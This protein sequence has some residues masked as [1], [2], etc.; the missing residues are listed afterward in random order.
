MVAAQDVAQEK[1][2]APQI[3]TVNLTLRE[4]EI[5]TH[6]SLLSRMDCSYS[7]PCAWESM[8]SL[9]WG[10]CRACRVMP[11]PPGQFQH[12]QIHDW[13]GTL[14]GGLVVREDGRFHAYGLGDGL[15][16]A[17]EGQSGAR[18]VKT[19][20]TCARQDMPD[21]RTKHSD[22]VGGGGT[23]LSARLRPGAVPAR[24]GRRLSGGRARHAVRRGDN[25]L[26]QTNADRRRGAVAGAAQPGRRGA[27]LRQ[28]VRL[29]V[30]VA[31]GAEH[32]ALV[33]GPRL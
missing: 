7:K 16:G 32:P 8:W 9:G 15:R 2:V 21:A 1:S 4:P 31:R 10:A 3:N 5:W 22:V 18:F 30:L 27:R 17:K 23:R 24:G 28:T 14:A 12:R 29:P 19:T 25:Q 33:T 20:N 11:R 26:Q 13:I 6:E